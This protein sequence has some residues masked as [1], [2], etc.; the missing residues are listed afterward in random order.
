MYFLKQLIGTLAKPMTIALLLVVVAAILRSYRRRRLAAVLLA[1]A[2]AFCYLGS[3]TSVG[4]ALLSPLESR[5]PPMRKDLP[6][7]AVEYVVVLGSGYS[8]RSSI[9]VSAALDEDSLRRIVE[10]VVLAR[11]LEARLVVSGGAPVGRTPAA[12]GYAALARELGIDDS[13]LV[14]L[15]QPLNTAE[16]AKAVAALL[17]DTPFILVTSAYHMP[18]AMRLMEDAGAHPIPAPAG[19]QM[20]KS[21]NNPLLWLVPSSIGLRNTEMALHE[22]LGFIALAL[23][24]G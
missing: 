6:H 20:K 9:P 17:N 21:A 12:L 19:H 22:Y 18:R 4:N 8:P 15:D 14:V 10:G 1:S 5:Y 23:G 7:P 24:I 16:E 11:R 3:L 13:S 2:A